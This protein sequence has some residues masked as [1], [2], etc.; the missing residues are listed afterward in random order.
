MTDHRLPVLDRRRAGV[1]LHLSSLEAPL[2]RGGRAFIDWLAEAGFGVWQF[3]PVGP[4]GADGS[5]YFAR[6][7]FAGNPAFI[8]PAEP[9]E[10]LPEEHTAFA[11]ATW[12]WLEDYALFEVLSEACEGE[13]WWSWPQEL[14]D[15]EPDALEAIRRGQAADLER[16]RLEQFAFFVQWRRLR[17]YARLRGVRLF[18][19]LPFYVGPM[20]AETWM[21][22]QQFQLDA[23]G[24]PTAV[25]GVPPDYFSE[26][27]QVWGNPLYD[28]QTLERER[29]AYWRSRVAAQ[30][31]RVDLLRI[32]HFRAFAAH[33]AVPAA[34]PDARG[35]RWC[36]TPGREFLKILR[37]ELGDLPIVAEDLGMITEDVVKLRKDF[38]LPG[39]RVLQFAFDG[40]PDNPHLPQQ[41]G[42][43]CVV[44]TGTHDNDTTLGWYLSLTEPAREYV[45]RVMGFGP[46]AM[47]EA[48]VRAALESAATLAVIP[49]Q[50]LLGLGSEARLNTPGTQGPR[51]W[52]WR[53]PS[54]AL[55]AQLAKH[56]GKIN[57]MCERA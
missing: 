41:L 23:A 21:Y 19:D 7:D 11:Q 5:P 9:P 12:D 36:P 25:A 6:S 8:D 27:G 18:G 45:D 53:L 34:A 44:Y 20:S 47:P 17:E 16:I 15:R 24:R 40:S 1:L 48:L 39:M 2:G 38:G 22:R 30:L 10:A 31:A 55:T 29:F 13:P 4:T 42:A 33:W 32:D 14:R 43:D 54:G 52:R 28:W 26:T 50:D 46:E 3:L 51:N 49:A 35:G 56:W 37:D 57:L